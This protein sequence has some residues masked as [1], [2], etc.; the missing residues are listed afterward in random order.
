MKFGPLSNQRV[1]NYW[2]QAAEIPVIG[3]LTSIVR[4]FA[5]IGQGAWGVMS[6]L[7]GNRKYTEKQFKAS[8]EGLK[9][10]CCEIIP[11][12]AQCYFNKNELMVKNLSDENLIEEK[13]IL[14][15]QN[16]GNL[17]IAESGWL[18]ALQS[19]HLK[20]MEK[21][22]FKTKQLNYDTKKLSDKDLLKQVIPKLL[23]EQ[24]DEA[25]QIVISEH[26]NRL[27]SSEGYLVVF[28]NY[29]NSKRETI[30]TIYKERANQL[31]RQMER[32]GLSK[33]LS[34]DS[35][36]F[37]VLNE[38]SAEDFVNS[39]KVHHIMIEICRVQDQ[40]TG[41]DIACFPNGFSDQEND[42]FK[43][44]REDLF[45]FLEIILPHRFTAMKLTRDLKTALT[46]NQENPREDNVAVNTFKSLLEVLEKFSNYSLTESEID[47]FVDYSNLDATIKELEGTK[48]RSNER[49]AQIG[50]DI[51]NLL[52]TVTAEQRVKAAQN[53]Q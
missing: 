17:S 9:K 53:E 30:Y 7:A 13:S 44:F 37:K 42:D 51:I 28:Q 20:R 11:F 27:Q 26:F 14:E 2:D 40:I 18:R 21:P 24:Q 35:E 4:I 31:A 10:G 34:K 1:N 33:D 49:L 50:R 29:N 12:I 39:A 43:Q 32:L 19:E 36:L 46:E 16:K 48:D 47:N 38:F 3:S 6:L 41:I 15:S 25:D 23:K 52:K 22:A 45:N 8:A 5:N